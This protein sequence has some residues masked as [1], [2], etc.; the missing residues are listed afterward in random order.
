MDPDGYIITMPVVQ[1]ARRIDVRVLQATPGPGT[2]WPHI[3]RQADRPR[4]EVDIAVVRSR[5]QPADLTFLNSDN[6][7]QGQLVLALASP[8]LQIP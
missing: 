5:A 8:A 6:L 1:G 2:A 7:R 3:V 4:R